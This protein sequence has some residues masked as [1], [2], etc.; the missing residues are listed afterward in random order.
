MNLDLI[1]IVPFHRYRQYV[2]I[3]DRHI[4]SQLEHIAYN[5]Q[6]VNFDDQFDIKKAE[7]DLY[8]RAFLHLVTETAFDYPHNSYGEKTFKPI[9][10][11]RPFILITVPKALKE[12]HDLGFKTFNQWWDEGYDDIVD[13]ISR[14]IKVIEVTKEICAMSMT[15]IK[16]MCLEMSDVLEHNH[17]HYFQTFRAQEIDRFELSCR[18]NLLPR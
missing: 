15:D 13:P 5:H 18:Q 10:S 3:Y 14:L 12:L 2:K 4:L 17:Y 8:Q 11:M 6:Y 7:P 9:A 1:Q 16:K